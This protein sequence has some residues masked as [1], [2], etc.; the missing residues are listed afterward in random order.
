MLRAQRRIERLQRVLGLAKRTEP[1]VH[2]IRF[3]DSQGNV[4]G[5][6]EISHDAAQRSFG[7]TRRAE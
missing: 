2:S 7:T 3:I 4:T 1:L 6:L 5:T